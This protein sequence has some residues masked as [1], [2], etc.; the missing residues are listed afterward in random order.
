M[1]QAVAEEAPNTNSYVVHGYQTENHYFASNTFH[2]SS[3]EISHAMSNCKLLV[4]SV[5]VGMNRGQLGFQY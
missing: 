5:A 1:F 2:S 3:L 4:I